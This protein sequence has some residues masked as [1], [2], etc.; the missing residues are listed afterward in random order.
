MQP[1]NCTK[2][3]RKATARTKRSLAIMIMSPLFSIRI[4]GGKKGTRVLTF[5]FGARRR[6]G[7]VFDRLD[8]TVIYAMHKNVLAFLALTQLLLHVLI[9]F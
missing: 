2:P 9:V 7:K 5:A 3:R 1:V 8:A 4:G 6:Q